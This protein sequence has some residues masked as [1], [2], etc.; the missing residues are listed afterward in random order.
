MCAVVAI[1]HQRWGERPLLVM[2]RREGFQFSADDV[3]AGLSRRLAKWQ[4]PDA[5]LFVDSLPMTATGKVSKLKLREQLA[6][7]AT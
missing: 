5:I 1:P 6:G 2:V 4:L 3:M 7:S